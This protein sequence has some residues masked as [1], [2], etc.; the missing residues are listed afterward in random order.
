LVIVD[1]L[2][3]AS[4]TGLRAAIATVGL[5]MIELEYRDGTDAEI[6]G[7]HGRGGSAARRNPMPPRTIPEQIADH[8]GTA[9]LRGEYAAGERIREQEL[10]D[11]HGVSRGPVR[12]AIRSLHKSGLVEFRPRRGAYAVG[13][14]LDLIA[15]FFNVRAALLG[16]AAR[17]FTRLASAEG[18]KLLSA[19]IA[20]L[21]ALAQAEPS[22]PVEFSLQSGAVGRVLYRYGGNDYLARTLFDQVHSSL[23]SAL[24]HERPFDYL[25]AERRQCVV[26]DWSSIVGFAEGGDE[27]GAERVARRILF[28]ARDHVLD[29]LRVVRGLT[30]HSAK[31]ISDN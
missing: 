26:D 2:I 3:A 20:R 30:V 7:L 16:L 24:W 18:L 12:E 11:L 27:A 17:C 13:V 23:W 28:E 19:E 25:T 10:A 31:L 9:I 5:G 4:F 29:S 22:A 15:D 6:S 8:L 1:N 21:Q 14:S